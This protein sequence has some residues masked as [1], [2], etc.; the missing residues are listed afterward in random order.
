MEV[1]PIY[2]VVSPLLGE[3]RWGELPS[4]ELLISQLAWLDFLREEWQEQW[5]ELRQGFTALSIRWKNSDYQTIF[6]NNVDRFHVKKSQLSSVTW[7]L[8]VC[9]DPEYGTDL[10]SLAHILRMTTHQIIDLHSSVT[11]RLHFFGF[12][13]G[14]MYL[15]GLPELLHVPRKAMPDRVIQAGSVAIGSSQTGI[16]PTKSPGGWHVIG[17]CPVLTFDA[18]SHPPVWAQPGDFIKFEQVDAEKMKNLLANPSFPIP[19]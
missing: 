1:R 2:I 19:R 17:K 10:H 4:D 16:Y 6:K 9:Y 8:P 7:K 18:H 13:P 5:I 14:F 12:L 3:L 11:Y 15:H